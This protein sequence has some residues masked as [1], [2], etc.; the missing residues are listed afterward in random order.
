M[1]K[2]IFSSKNNKMTPKNGALE[3][4]FV[5]NLQY[6]SQFSYEI[7]K[8]SI[9]SNTILNRHAVGHVTQ[10]DTKDIGHWTKDFLSLDINYVVTCIDEAYNIYI[11]IYLIQ[12]GIYILYN[13]YIINIFLKRP[14]IYI[15]IHIYTNRYTMK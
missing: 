1:R 13:I 3:I 11:Y 15:H 5:W 2:S 8:N 4:S 6:S 9:I 10:L 7:Y 14:V 12:W